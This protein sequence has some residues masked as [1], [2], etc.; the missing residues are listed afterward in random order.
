MRIDAFCALGGYDESFTHNEDAE[1]DHRL[2]AAGGRIWMEANAQIEYYPRKQ[3]LTLLKQYY[4]YGVGRARNVLK[5][6]TIPKIRQAI[7][8]MI[9]PAI[10]VA[11]ASPVW[12]PFALP[13]LIWAGLCLCYAIG[14]AIS[15][16]D[17]CV[18]MSGMAAMIMHFG[19]SAGFLTCL[20]RHGLIRMRSTLKALIFTR[21]K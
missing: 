21:P 10:A 15:D 13:A 6:G 7:P 17:P 2:T 18:L 19:W 5:H 8:L 12:W 4:N 14:L 9:V 16:R 20:T 3:P 11:L 1:L